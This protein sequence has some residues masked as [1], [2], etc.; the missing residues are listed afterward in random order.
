MKL[1]SQSHLN[2][3]LKSNCERYS[4][5]G[6]ALGVWHKGQQTIAN[7]GVLSNSS[8]MPVT[9][10]SMFQ[11]GSI[12]KVLTATV[13][14]QLVDKGLIE[15][16]KPVKTYLTGFRVAD[17]DA[18]R[19][20]TV[21]QLLNHT[22][23]LSG[24]LMTDCGCGDNALSRYLDCC[25]LLP[26]AH[27][28]GDGFSYSNSAFVIAGRLIEVVSGLS[29]HQALKHYLW[30][31]LKLEH[32]A[33]DPTEFP[34]RSVAI[35]HTPD[36]QEP[37]LLKPVS[38]MFIIPATTAPAGATP[39][40]SA[41][42]LIAFAS[43]HLNGGQTDEGEQILTPQACELMQ[44]EEVTI[45]VAPRDIHKWGL[46]WM[47][48]EPVGG[49]LIGHDGATLGQCAYMR[50]DPKSETIAVL[51][52]NHGSA[53]DMMMSVFADTFD[54]LAGITPSPVPTIAQEQPSDLSKYEGRYCTVAAKHN[55]YVSNGKL[56]L[57]SW[58]HIDELELDEPPKTLEYVGDDTFMVVNKVGSYPALY[59]F[60]QP[61]EKG[62]PQVLFSGLRVAKRDG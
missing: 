53:N 42:D 22:S 46:G 39:M 27:P 59:S 3:V 45:P 31:P 24:D 15:L 34:C 9:D 52:T 4:V 40:M 49:R 10:A 36:P 16:D 33:S 50:I 12:T 2:T 29:Y 47:I 23:G 61:D 19:N 54:K 55:V 7:C 62:K 38:S 58:Q 18:S 13:V 30:E 25:R 60:L 41:S 6:A 8:Q 28:V 48:S 21:R 35:G 37:T 26:L 17:L 32:S 44:Q 56:M 20:I 1:L 43:M 51:L 11:I 14:M 5:P 57:K